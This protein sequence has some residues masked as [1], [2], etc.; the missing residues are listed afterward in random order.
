ML[1]LDAHWL[2]TLRQEDSL[3]GFATD[4]N[5]PVRIINDPDFYEAVCRMNMFLFSDAGSHEKEAILIEF[6]SNYDSRQG[7]HIDSLPAVP[8]LSCRLRPVFEFLSAE[9]ATEG[10]LS[11]LADLANM[12]RYQ[13]IRTFK[14]VTGMTPHAWQ[15]NQRIDLARQLIRCGDRIADVAHRL[16]FADQAHF[17]RVFKAHAGVTPGT[18]RD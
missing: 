10:S 16:G 12:S 9:P 14:K 5:E 11:V 7:R 17:Q 3:T 2:T 1:H 8:D 4:A 6:V 13:L 15:L 18:F